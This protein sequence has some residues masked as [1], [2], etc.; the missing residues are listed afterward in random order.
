M[1][2]QSVLQFWFED[3]PPKNHFNSSPAFDAEIRDKFEV[4]AIDNAAM[5]SQK[6]HPWEASPQ[7]AL[8]LI[9]T[10][11]QFPRNMYRDTPA[12]F[13]WDPIALKVAK[14]AIKKGFDLNI[15]QARRSFIY[16][17]FMH[18][19][20]LEEQRRCVAYIDQRLDNENT[21][22]HAE[23]HMKV[24]EQFGRFPHRNIILGRESTEAELRYLSDG[25]Y[26]P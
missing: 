20:I 1:D 24:I 11:D 6:I 18:S 10:L 4:M 3:T 14:R 16:M 21:L 17:P 9:I 19:E 22:F 5:A 2:G 8:A 12:A 13:S 15:P 7:T 26:T 25:G 23:A